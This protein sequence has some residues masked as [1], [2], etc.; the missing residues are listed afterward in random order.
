MQGVQL[1]GL[2][3]HS[4]PISAGLSSTTFCGNHIELKVYMH[5]VTFWMKLAFL[6]DVMADHY[7]MHPAILH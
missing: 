4:Y 6:V 3:R 1:L 2:K 7:Q 5:A